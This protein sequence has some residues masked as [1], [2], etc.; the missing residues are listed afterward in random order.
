MHFCTI[1]VT[2]V[3]MMQVLFV[4]RKMHQAIVSLCYQSLG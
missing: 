3:D 4:N 2:V 1:V